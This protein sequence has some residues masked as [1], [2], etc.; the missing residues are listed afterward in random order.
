M[1]GWRMNWYWLQLNK[2]NRGAVKSTPLF[3]CIFLK[4]AVALFL[5]TLYN[6]IKIKVQS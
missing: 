2:S 6:I 3:F 4:L 1:R 5:N